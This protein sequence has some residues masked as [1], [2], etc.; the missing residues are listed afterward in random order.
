MMKK[1]VSVISLL[2]SAAPLAAFDIPMLQGAH[3][4][5]IA[6][7]SAEV[8]L[9]AGPL[10]LAP[11]DMPKMLVN[12]YPGRP[13]G[14]QQDLY[15]NG[16]V[17]F[18]FKD[19][20]FALKLGFRKGKYDSYVKNYKTYRVLLLTDLTYYESRANLDEMFPGL[21][22]I[23]DNP[24]DDSYEA[25]ISS[26]ENL[27]IKRF[28]KFLDATYVNKATGEEEE[29][30]STKLSDLAQNWAADAEKYAMKYNGRKIYAVPQML[31][32]DYATGNGNPFGFVLSEG[33][34]LYH[35]TGLPLDFAEVY[36]YDFD[37][38][39]TLWKPVA[40]SIPMSIAFEKKENG[41]WDI[42][43]ITPQELTDVL[44]DDAASAARR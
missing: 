41:D 1:L 36:R 23:V 8:P 13:G 3:A 35:T 24:D 37:T 17:T 38:D 25:F 11:T 5:D 7:F 12:A 39:L 42:R 33:S 43:D 44:D 15:V 32:E 29:V 2:L 27:V 9:A 4:G 6:A 20:K 31:P 14:T 28:A 34:P 26:D 30:F 16:G 22:D 18:Q 19:H 40:Y 21:L 10:R